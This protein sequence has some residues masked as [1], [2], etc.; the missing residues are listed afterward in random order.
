L[1]GEL[2]LAQVEAALARA[3][4]DP[5]NLPGLVGLF[6]VMVD[7]GGLSAL[8]LSARARE[9][10]GSAVAGARSAAQNRPALLVF[11]DVDKFDAPSRAVVERLLED[12]GTTSLCVV[13]TQARP[14]VDGKGSS[15]VQLEVTPFS[16]QEVRDLAR[17]ALGEMPETLVPGMMRESGG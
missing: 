11:E 16:E 14:T 1:S 5:S 10:C 4:L 2:T 3:Q 9:Y 13:A 15:A 6:G 17:Q 7:V 8:E 12:P